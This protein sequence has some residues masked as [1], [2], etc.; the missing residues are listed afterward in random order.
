MTT[1]CF[2][3]MQEQEHMLIEMCNDT[4]DEYQTLLLLFDI[5]IPFYVVMVDIR[6]PLIPMPLS[7]FLGPN[8]CNLPQASNLTI[9]HST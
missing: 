6:L 1:T 3:A 5:K 9:S 4:N 2:D 7:P 8:S